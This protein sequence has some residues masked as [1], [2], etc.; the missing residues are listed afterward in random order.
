MII[1][2]SALREPQKILLRAPNWIGDA[3]MSLPALEALR[4]RFPEA[5][6]VLV[7]KPWVSDVYAH[8]PAV[9]RQIIYDAQ[10]EHRGSA[11]FS[12]LI[13]Q[14]REERFEAAILFQN[15]FHAAWMAW[16]A[17]IPTRVGYARD[18]RARLLT[19]S[20][21]TPPPAAYGHQAYYY[22]HLL[23]RAGI[24]ERPDPP[25][26]L[27]E[28]RLIVPPEERSWAVR[29]VE[30]LG[31]PGPR[32][33]VGVVPGASFGPAKRWPAERF[34]ELADRL[35]MA[36]HAD[37][38][39]FGAASERPLAEEVAQEMKHT[40]AI[41]AG[42]ATL[43]QS[44]ALLERCRLVVTN[45]SGMMHVAAALAL[46]VVAIFG[47]TDPDATGPFGPNAR[48]VRHEVECS[49]CGLR[50]CPIDFRC[51][52]GLDVNV[53]YRAALELVKQLGAAHDRTASDR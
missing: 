35:A 46:P 4:V 33:L 47:S 7:S 13:R 12:K 50:V 26:A 15:A 25:R 19:E 42:E 51:M 32:F 53:V 43:R 17:G 20:I 14:L 45:D 40:P 41:V 28:I 11:G 6:I 9:D 8:H 24:I 23:F 31:L 29:Y 30:S 37:V 16:R 18:A 39:L 27:E 48:V 2:G 22:L 44:M 38:V 34:A 5:E 52:E 1:R 49:P 10:G 21:E 3:V 36:L